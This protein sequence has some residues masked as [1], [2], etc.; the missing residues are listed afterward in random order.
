MLLLSIN[1]AY[2]RRTIDL[3]AA[4]GQTEGLYL[5][6]D[7]VLAC[8]PLV[9]GDLIQIKAWG[10]L[11]AGREIVTVPAYQVSL[12]EREQRLLDAWKSGNQAEAV[13]ATALNSNAGL[14]FR[15]L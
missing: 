15:S 8:A 6:G 11:S 2:D 7:G 1:E 9:A 12:T 5:S 14:R 3:L 10:S 13:A 4:I